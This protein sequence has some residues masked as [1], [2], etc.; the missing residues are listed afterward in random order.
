MLRKHIKIL[1][2][3][4]KFLFKIFLKFKMKVVFYLK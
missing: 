4:N 1:F 2:K 3:I